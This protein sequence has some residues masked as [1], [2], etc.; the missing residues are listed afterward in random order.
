MQP[1]GK[2][3]LTRN[4]NST[5]AP[6]KTIRVNSNGAID[7]TFNFSDSVSTVSYKC[8][9]LQPDGKILIS[10]FSIAPY[11]QNKGK[12]KRLNTDGSVDLSYSMPIGFNTEAIDLFALSNGKLIATGSFSF[13]NGLE[14][15]SIVRIM[16]EDYYF[17]QG[18]NKLDINNNGCDAADIVFPNLKFQVSNTTNAIQYISNTSGSDKIALT[19]GKYTITPT[20]ENPSYFSASP[21]NIT[22]DFPTKTSPVLQDFCISTIGTHRDLEISIIPITV[23]R[24]GFD[25]TYKIVFKNKG[26]QVQSGSVVFTYDDAVTDLVSTLP[27]VT[28]QSGNKLSWD[29]INLNPFESREI[30]VV[31]NLNTPTE[32]PPLNNGELLNFTVSLRIQETDETPNDNEFLFPQAVVGSYDPNDKTCLEG[33][34]ISKTKVGDYVHYQIRFENSGTYPAQNIIVKD[35]IDTSKFDISTLIPEKGSHSFITRIVEGN[36]VE[37]VFENI[38]LPFDDA[39][40]DGYVTFKIKTVSALVSGNTFSN[41]A[42]I[43]FDYNSAVTTNISTTT[44]AS[45]LQNDEFSFDNYF[46]IYPN[47]VDDNLKIHKN[48]TIEVKSVSVFNVLGQV[49][50]VI[51][52]AINIENIDV[53]SL[54]TGTY[55][56]KINSDRGTSNTKFVKM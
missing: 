45:V 37:F 26:N 6:M 10:G 19:S 27:I 13:Y 44:V 51:P 23:A 55:F 3:L 25:A 42:S 39:S 54:K 53:S 1:D 21:T 52:N 34:T 4:T 48:N 9:A 2:I 12:I 36:K 17:L 46:V 33:A 49:V 5:F 32:T 8:L 24:P 22:V 20:F 43:Y 7:T 47:P 11:V 38:N 35:V 40:N 41:S 50:M 14:E 16:G 31:L 29:F 18:Q 15:R 30:D 28:A 56:I